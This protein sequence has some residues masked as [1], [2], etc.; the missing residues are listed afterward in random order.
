RSPPM[1]TAPD[2]PVPADLQ[3]FWEWDKMHLPRPMTPFTEEIFTAAVSSGFTRAMDEVAY[4]M[5]IVYRP[6]NHYGYMGMVPQDLKGE[7]MEQR[8]GRFKQNVFPFSMSVGVRWEKE[9]LPSILPGLEK[10]K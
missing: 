7:T 9:W 8:A 5:G 1:T 10:A 3:G 2:F 4:P 6:F